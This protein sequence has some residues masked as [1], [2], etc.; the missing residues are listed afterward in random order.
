[1]QFVNLETHDPAGHKEISRQVEAALE[2]GNFDRARSILGV[3]YDEYPNECK[4][5]RQMLVPK[6]GTML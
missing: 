1:M 5:L 3:Y 6:W 4:Q 2:T